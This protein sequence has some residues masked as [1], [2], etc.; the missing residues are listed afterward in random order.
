MDEEEAAEK[1]CAAAQA[2]QDAE[3]A[4]LLAP[5]FDP[6][7]SHQNSGTGLFLL[8]L[9]SLG[10]CC[11]VSNAQPPLNAMSWLT[12]GLIAACCSQ[13]CHYSK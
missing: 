12:A 1:Q 10:P 5:I 9:Q 6:P 3:D 11:H 8:L 2:A 4:E 7:A 13:Q